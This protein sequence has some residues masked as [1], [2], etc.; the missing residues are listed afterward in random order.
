VTTT[1]PKKGLNMGLSWSFLWGW[2]LHA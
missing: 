1:A 2:L